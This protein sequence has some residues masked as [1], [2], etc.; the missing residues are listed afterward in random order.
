MQFKN[1]ERVWTFLQ[2]RYTN[3]QQI[4]AQR[5]MQIKTIMRYHLTPIRTATENGKCCQG[6][7]KTAIFAHFC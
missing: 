6:C 2:R 4:T 3:T 5:E 1:G 7:A